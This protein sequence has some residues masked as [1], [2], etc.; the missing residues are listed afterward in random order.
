MQK[1]AWL[2]VDLLRHAQL[3]SV[4]DVP[5]TGRP[6]RDAGEDETVF[7]TLDDAA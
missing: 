2:I 6:F 7:R 4:V 5:D 3:Q 1:A